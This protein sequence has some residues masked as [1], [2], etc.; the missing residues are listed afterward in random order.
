MIRLDSAGDMNT[1]IQ[2]P[3]PYHRGNSSDA[4]RSLGD[5]QETLSQV[6]VTGICAMAGYAI[7]QT[8]PDVDK[9]DMTVAGTVSG[10]QASVR[11]QL[12]ATYQDGRMRDDSF[13]YRIK[14]DELRALLEKARGHPNPFV[15]VVLHLP[16]DHSEWLTNN[17]DRLTLQHCAYW[18]AC[19]DI[20]DDTQTVHIPRT[21]LFDVRSIRKLMDTSAERVRET[22]ARWQANR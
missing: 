22:Q 5:I 4:R 7:G 9:V 10:T 11:L 19:E 20:D 1:D 18:I 16:S 17:A 13:T 15:L 21:N 8:I 2:P 12:K 14:D 3:P 6:Y